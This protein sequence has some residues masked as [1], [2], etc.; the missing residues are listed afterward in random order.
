MNCLIALYQL[1]YFVSENILAFKLAHSLPSR[2]ADELMSG[3]EN[4]QG[5]CHWPAKLA[6][7]LRRTGD[8]VAPDRRR[9][10]NGGGPDRRRRRAGQAPTARRTGAVGAMEGQ[11]TGDG[12]ATEWFIHAPVGAIPL[13]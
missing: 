9:I 2:T 13:T 8:A 6:T 5:R 3:D 7:P 4:A 1:S 11:R 10:G 12:G